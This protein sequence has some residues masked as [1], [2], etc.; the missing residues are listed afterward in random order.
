MSQFDD[1]APTKSQEI[2]MHLDRFIRLPEVQNLT[3]MSRSAVYRLIQR[4]G[5]PRP[6]RVGGGISAWSQVEIAEWQQK[7]LTRRDT[8]VSGS[9]RERNSRGAR[10]AGFSAGAMI[11]PA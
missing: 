2:V 7:H 10:R 8:A 5:F 11:D 1:P 9:E 4:G 3:G 6:C